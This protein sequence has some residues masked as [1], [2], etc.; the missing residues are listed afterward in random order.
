M[1]NR[2][3]EEVM[4]QI[5]LVH[6]PPTATVREAAEQMASKHVSSIAVSREGTDGLVG[7]FTERDLITRVVAVGKDPETTPLE[8]VMTKNP[9]TVTIDHTVMQAI[10]EMRENELRHLPVTK[11]G[12]VI[13]MVSVRDFVGKEIAE[14][15]DERAYTKGYWEHMR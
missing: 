7:I 15:D 3:I 1:P 14:L 8:G 12:K 10:G 6:L 4:S 11:N 9:V 5:P 13:S 2:R